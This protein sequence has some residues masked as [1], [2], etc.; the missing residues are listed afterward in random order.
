MKILVIYFSYSGN[1]RL[2]AEYLGKRIGGDICP[3]VEEKRRTF[4]TIILDMMFNREPNIKNLEYPISYY[5]CRSDLGL[6]IGA[7]NEVVG[8]E[9]KS[10]SC[11]L[12][13]YITMRL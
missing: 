2:L 12:F 3:I 4:L 1:N 10:R 11:Q 7:S 6:K 8:Q 5:T 9:G 13:L